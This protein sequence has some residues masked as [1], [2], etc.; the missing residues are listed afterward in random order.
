MLI[1]EKDSDVSSVTGWIGEVLTTLAEGQ[2]DPT[3]LVH[4]WKGQGNLRQLPT[5]PGMSQNEALSLLESL[6][7][8][9]KLGFY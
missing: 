5:V 6:R 4:V 1:K 2:I 9:G 7:H 3:G 8:K